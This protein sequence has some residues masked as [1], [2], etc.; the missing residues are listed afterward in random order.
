MPISKRCKGYTIRVTSD[1]PDIQLSFQ[2]IYFISLPSLPFRINKIR[3]TSS[4]LAKPN[5]DD[6][7]YPLARA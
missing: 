6:A 2:R 5:L 3:K 7:S 4:A 1:I